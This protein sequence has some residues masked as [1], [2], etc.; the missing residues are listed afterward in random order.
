[1]K[2]SPSSQVANI[3]IQFGKVWKGDVQT[4]KQR[5]NSESLQSL[6]LAAYP[7]TNRTAD[8]TGEPVVGQTSAGCRSN[9]WIPDL[10]LPLPTSVLIN[11]LPIYLATKSRYHQLYFSHRVVGKAKQENGCE[12]P[13]RN[14]L[15]TM[16]ANTNHYFYSIM[17][18]WLHCI[19]RRGLQNVGNSLIQKEFWQEAY[20]FSN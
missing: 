18:T 10:V 11:F 20:Y 1:M 2:H 13:C 6:L 15:S 9:T 12:I 4:T 3:N 16:Y 19:I 8:P 7:Y 17:R 14:V 5:R